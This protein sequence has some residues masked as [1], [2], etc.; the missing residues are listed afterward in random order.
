MYTTL[1]RIWTCLYKTI[2]D[3]DNS[4]LIFVGLF[5]GE[6]NISKRY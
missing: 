3:D 6:V 4:V 1:S 2:L 5:N